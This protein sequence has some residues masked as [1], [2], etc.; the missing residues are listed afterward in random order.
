MIC[1]SCGVEAPTKYVAF[2]QNIGALVM[3]F[4]KSIE[5]NLCKRCIHK[6]FWEFTPITFF[7]GWWGTIS[8]FVTP[9]FLLN[10]TFRYLFCLGMQRPADNAVPPRL[11]DD[12]VEKLKPYTQEIFERLGNGEKLEKIAEDI[13]PRA[14]VTP[15]QVI[16]WTVAVAEQLKK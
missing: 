1:Q 3:R 16:L 15:G 11:G 14:W 13:A 10:N 4:H 2:Y 12:T 6:Y 8:L 9:C 7:A 5:G